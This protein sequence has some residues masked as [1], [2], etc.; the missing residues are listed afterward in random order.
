MTSPIVQDPND[1]FNRDYNK[2][3][4]DKELYGEDLTALQNAC[5]A[6]KAIKDAGARLMYVVTVLFPALMK[7]REANIGML[8]DGMNVNTDMRNEMAKAQDAINDMKG[9]TPNDSI[10][11]A[12]KFVT[13]M[14]N[15]KVMVQKSADAGI[16]DPQSASALQNAIKGITSQF[17][18]T[19]GHINPV[20]VA[21]LV[22]K[23]WGSTTSSPQ[24]KN[25]FNGFQSV[26][27]TVSALSTSTGTQF[28]FYTN[29]Y[30]QVLNLY[31]TGFMKP[32]NQQESAIIQNTSRSG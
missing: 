11:D 16:I 22:P 21:N 10:I 8:S 28:S 13:A 9:K 1:D 27:Q 4:Q 12:A 18:N 19:N 29:Q 24:I 23:W 6:L 17:P 30:N 31:N 25:I 32:I 5:A 14:N 15:L 20:D 2:Y 26:N 7:T 3:L